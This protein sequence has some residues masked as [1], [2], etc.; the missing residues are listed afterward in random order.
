MDSTLGSALYNVDSDLASITGEQIECRSGSAD[1]FPC[2]E[3]D[4]VSFMTRQEIGAR[5]GIQV[6]DV[7]GWEDEETGRE[8]ALGRSH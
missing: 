1:M 6:N 2:N 4:L 5:R 3:V 7:W 8:Y